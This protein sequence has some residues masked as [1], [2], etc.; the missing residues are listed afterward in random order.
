MTAP[1]GWIAEF[2]ARKGLKYTPDADERWIRVWEPF[3]T[4]K[5]PHRYEHVL[6]QTGEIGSVTVARMLVGMPVRVPSGEV[7]EGEAGSW[8]AIA[9]DVRVKGRAAATTE[10]GAI[11]GDALDLVAMRRRTTGDAAF[12]DLFASFAPSSEDLALAIT[13]SVRKLVVGW[14]MPLHFEVRPGGFIVAPIALPAD[15]ASLSWFLKAVYAFGDKAA[16]SPRGPRV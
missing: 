14:R 8:I 10:T 2:A 9:Q 15:A 11:Y 1:I 3:V 4:L 13:P 6:E 12:D 16:K 5:T 7:V